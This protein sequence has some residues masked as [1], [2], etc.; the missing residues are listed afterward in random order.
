LQRIGITLWASF[1][2]C[3]LCSISA[4]LISTL[5]PTYVSEVAKDLSSF[6]AG[7]GSLGDIPRISA[8]INSIFL[9]G[10]T[11]GGF[12]WG[13]ISDRIG[14]AKALALSV[15]LLGLFTLLVSFA[16]SWEWVV[17]VRLLAGFAVGGILVIT[18][19]LLSEIW[20][21]SSRSVV[22]GIDSVGFPIGIFS[23]GVLS[24]FANNW[25]E[26]FYIGTLPIIFGILCLFLLLESSSWR[27]TKISGSATFGSKSAPNLIRGSIIFGSMLVGLWGMFSW[28]PSWVVDEMNGHGGVAMMSLGAGGIAGG[29][30]SGWLSNGLGVRRAMLIC[31]SGCFVVSFLLFGMNAS[32]SNVIYGELAL[33]SLFF[34]ISQGLLSIYIPQLFP[35]QVRGTS[36]GICFNVGRIVTTLAVLFPGM[37]VSTAGT[38]GKALLLFA[39]IFIIGFIAVYLTRDQQKITT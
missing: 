31:F 3:F 34:G 29:F 2:M 28:I 18:P 25:R 23:T 17:A 12:T 36:T 16:T 8:I 37:I 30:V 33:L 38:Y 9:A 19:T 22:I 14:R 13:L 20:P 6:P 35:Y 27:K 1:I 32:F 10:W 5:M 4:G 21:A 7:H 39:G 15:G 26:A 24:S 11:I